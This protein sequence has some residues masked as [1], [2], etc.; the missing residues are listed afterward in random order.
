MPDLNAIRR[1]REGELIFHDVRNARVMD[2]YAVDWKT[3]TE[4]FDNLYAGRWQLVWPNEF[5]EET[6]P[7]V[8]N[9]V[10]FGTDDIAALVAENQPQVRFDPASDDA[11]D[12]EHA[13]LLEQ[14][15]HT[16]WEFNERRTADALE[17][18]LPMDLIA[19][20]AA[21]VAVT[22]SP[23]ES[24]PVYTRLDP[25]GCYPT[26]AQGRLVDL[27]VVTRMKPR[28]AEA[29]YG[30][31]LDDLFTPQETSSVREIE[32]LDY[33][34]MTH[35]WR[36]V[37]LAGKDGRA[38][39]SS[40]LGQVWHH[41]LGRVPVAWAVTR[42]ADGRIRGLFDS[43]KGI[44][45]AQ[46]R[47]L[48]LIVDYAD[49]EVYAPWYAYDIINDRDAPGPRTIYRGRSPDARIQRVA[50]AGSNPQ[51]FAVL[52]YLERQVRAN[53]SYPAQ[54]QGEVSQSIASASFVDRTLGQLA[55]TVKQVQRRLAHLR[56]Q[57]I[58]VGFSVDRAFLDERKPL[59][60]PYKDRD[61]YVPSR[62][63]PETYRCRVTYGAGAGLDA[64][65]KRAAL[66]QDLAAGIISLEDAREQTDYL[67]KPGEVAAK[68]QRE[69]VEEAILQRMVTDP[70]I[71]I[72]TLLRLAALLADGDTV[73]EA[74]TK[75]AALEE[76]ARAEQQ[77]A[78]GTG[79]VLPPEPAP[80]TA[81]GLAAGAM[82]PEASMVFAPPP[83]LAMVRPPQGR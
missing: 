74:A 83:Q 50:P 69:Q 53:A 9:I 10:R 40:G 71:G 52:E 51:L 67:I 17:S 59:L 2:D 55:T 76:Q 44:L 27:L 7:L 37:A 68:R 32:I 81:E 12:V 62:D 82:P 46:N 28:E 79:G 6:E 48:T 8:A 31:R 41:D 42:G 5:T 11:S 77:A 49:Q 26:F 19:T 63:I 60:S 45:W 38:Y 4:V 24:Y 23:G 21:F 33:Y 65:N 66:H 39:A 56:R 80:P 72:D 20:G 36:A 1:E 15:A 47:L 14:I 43:T 34:T 16:H 58:E 57:L 54:R 35:V 70:Q 18:L 29:A 64:L 73:L 13:Y 3:R 78:A 30:F 75:M 61:S 25:R 22:V